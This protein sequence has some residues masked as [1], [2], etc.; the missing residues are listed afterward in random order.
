MRLDTMETTKRRAPNVWYISEAKSEEIEV[1]EY[2]AEDVAKDLLLKTISRIGAK[3][4]IE[5]AM[6]ERNIEVE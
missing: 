2:V 5:V 4:K 6:Y 3:T 1:E